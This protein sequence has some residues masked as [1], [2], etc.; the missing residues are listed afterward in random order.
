MSW[1]AKRLALLF[2]LIAIILILLVTIINQLDIGTILKRLVIGGLLFGFLGGIIGQLIS[3]NL[4][5]SNGKQQKNNF[6]SEAE[7]NQKNGNH[8]EEEVE[9]FEFDTVDK[10]EENVVNMAQEAPEQM[11]DMVKNM[12]E[13]E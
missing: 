7:E 10:A 12:T 9:P 5:K 3:Y 1:L 11:A 4:Y 6:Q 8:E 2:F 13:E